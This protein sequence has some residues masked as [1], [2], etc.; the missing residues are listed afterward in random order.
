MNALREFAE[1]PCYL[2][3]DT[4]LFINDKAFGSYIVLSVYKDR[5]RVSDAVLINDD[6]RFQPVTLTDVEEM[7]AALQA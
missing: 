3:D 7:L 2:G 4:L 6:S 5:G 1:R